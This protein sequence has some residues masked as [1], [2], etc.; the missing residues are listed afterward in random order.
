MAKTSTAV[1]TASGPQVNLVSTLMRFAPSTTR[2]G[3]RTLEQEA[4]HGCVGACR[5]RLGKVSAF[6]RATST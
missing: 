2:R 1:E 4:M 6:G 5:L 3:K